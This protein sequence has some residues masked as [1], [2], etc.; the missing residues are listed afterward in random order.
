MSGLDL[1]KPEVLAQ[2]D[3]VFVDL[4]EVNIRVDAVADV[5]SD[6]VARV[7]VD[8][9]DKLIV[10]PTSKELYNLKN[11]PDDRTDIATQHPDKVQKLSASIDDWLGATPIIFPG[12]LTE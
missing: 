12:K 7:V 1:R 4:Y 2:R 3:R 11:D 8:G 6:L 9:W 5:D 10:R